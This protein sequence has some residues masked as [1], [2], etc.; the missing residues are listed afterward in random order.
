MLP[1]T[2]SIHPLVLIR[3]CCTAVCPCAVSPPPSPG[4]WSEVRLI[5]P[6]WQQECASLICYSSCLLTT[7]DIPLQTEPITQPRIVAFLVATSGLR[8][9]HFYQF[10]FVP[11]CLSFQI[12]YFIIQFRKNVYVEKPVWVLV[13]LL[14]QWSVLTLPIRHHNTPPPS[15]HHITLITVTRT[16]TKN[17]CQDDLD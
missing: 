6:R 15:P 9:Y 14:F 1:R 12:I 13:V 10:I 5:N 17:T 8:C 2:R 11:F 16:L 7:G 4:H 3:L